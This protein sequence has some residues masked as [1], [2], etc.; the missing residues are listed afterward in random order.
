MVPLAVPGAVGI[1]AKEVQ[2]SNPIG[3][4]GEAITAFRGPRLIPA[5]AE[6]FAPTQAIAA[7]NIGQITGKGTDL[8]LLGMLAMSRP[9]GE[10]GRRHPKDSGS[11]E[12]S[13]KQST[14]GTARPN[15][16]ES[17][18]LKQ[19]HKQE[20]EKNKA[21]ATDKVNFVPTREDIKDLLLALKELANEISRQVPR[22]YFKPYRTTCE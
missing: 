2:G 1:V 13:N 15:K 6:G 21:S 20:S 19:E 14:Q 12:S 16:A 9:Q 4:A 17:R 18:A 7:A 11:V 5:C 22:E 10:F 8:T 3:K